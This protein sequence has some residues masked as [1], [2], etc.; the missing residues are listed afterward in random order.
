MWAPLG[1]P[2]VP[3]PVGFLGGPTTPGRHGRWNL[4][5]YSL[6]VLQEGDPHEVGLGGTHICVPAHTQEQ[7]GRGKPLGARTFSVSRKTVWRG[8]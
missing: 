8:N 3:P 4:T 5:P 2:S 6:P 7:E 1:S